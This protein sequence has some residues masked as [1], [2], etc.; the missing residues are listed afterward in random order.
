MVDN[1][2][3]ID[4]NATAIKLKCAV[5]EEE[6]LG[7]KIKKDTSDAAKSK[8][9]LIFPSNP[10]QREK[11]PSIEVMAEN[12]SQYFPRSILQIEDYSYIVGHVPVLSNTPFD[13]LRQCSPAH[14]CPKVILVLHSVPDDESL[15]EF[16]EM[17]HAVLSLGPF[18]FKEVYKFIKNRYTSHHKPIHQLYLP[19]CPLELFEVKREAEEG[20]V[21]DILNMT[22][23][24]K[25]HETQDFDLAVAATLK[26][27]EATYNADKINRLRFRLSAV[28]S[29]NQDS[30]AWTEQFKVIH[31]EVNEKFNRLDFKC[32][33][34]DIKS[35]L[36]S[37]SVSILPFQLKTTAFGI[38]AL[39][40]AY[41]GLPVLVSNSAGVSKY[42]Q[43]LGHIESDPL[44]NY[45][46]NF[47]EDTEEWSKRLKEKLCHPKEAQEIADK[48]RKKCLVNSTIEDSHL[49]FL[50]IIAGMC[51]FSNILSRRTMDLLILLCLVK[52]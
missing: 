37:S 23:D 50:H 51:D 24:T 20:G 21:T 16:L 46:G 52:H 40:A 2:R 41:A 32:E 6:S 13:L 17:S 31:R 29:S 18:I 42:L 14:T 4:P 49:K 7:D 36:K 22:S 27:S 8:V 19:G 38:E 11:L 35:W 3:V 43:N 26:A 25:E 33:G 39:W 44:V 45:T 12:C 47:E 1:I 5:F 9:M 10:R 48:I 30:K 28:G 34:N 15:K